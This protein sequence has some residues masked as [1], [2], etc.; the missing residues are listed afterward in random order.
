MTTTIDPKAALRKRIIHLVGSMNES[1]LAEVLKLVEYLSPQ[2]A[3]EELKRRMDA[4]RDS[5]D[6]ELEQH[7]GPTAAAWLFAESLAVL[8]ASKNLAAPPEPCETT[9]EE[10]HDDC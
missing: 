1:R 7:T 5:P 6:E 8:R 9:D 2:A 3:E 10:K 4:R